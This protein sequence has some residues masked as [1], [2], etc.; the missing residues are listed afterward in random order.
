LT[1]QTHASGEHV[2]AWSPDGKRIAAAEN[3]GIV[4]ILDVAAGKEIMTYN[5]GTYEQI[6]NLS[7]S[8]DGK[9]IATANVADWHVRIWDTDTGKTITTYDIPDA[10]Q[11]IAWAPDS[12]S[13]A[14]C[15]S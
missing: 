2:L 11:H 15:T 6:I 13:L 10:A 8:P 14:I 3:N 9:Y 4:R 5:D 12:K 1:F 7:W